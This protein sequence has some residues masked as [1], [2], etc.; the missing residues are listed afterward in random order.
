M[1]SHGKE[2]LADRRASRA[3]TRHNAL[4]AT[5]ALAALVVSSL[6]F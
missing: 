6:Q 5:I 2:I 4:Y 1:I 3:Y